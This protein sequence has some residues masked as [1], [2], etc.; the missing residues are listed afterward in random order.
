M[1]LIQWILLGVLILIGAAA[2]EAFVRRNR[3]K[4]SLTAFFGAEDT[5]EN[6]SVPLGMEA[7]DLDLIRVSEQGNRM[8]ETRDAGFRK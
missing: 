7:T 2:I 3:P 4:K 1:T 5:A 8:A 6:Q